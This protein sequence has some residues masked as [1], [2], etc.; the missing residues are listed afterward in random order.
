MERWKADTKFP[1]Y[2]VSSLAQVR[3]ARTGKIKKQRIHASG[4]PTVCLWGNGKWAKPNSIAVHRL[5][6]R[7]FVPGDTSLTVN[8]KNG[9]KTDNR[10]SNLEWVTAAENV[11]HARRTGLTVAPQGEKCGRSK[12]VDSE[13]RRIRKLYERG[14]TQ[15]AIA[16]MFK[17]TQAN[18]SEI[19][20]YKT[21]K[22]I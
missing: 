12:L 2:E 4:Y 19:V 18:V 7:A 14:L 6:A 11:S 1:L 3:N 21:W 20:R 8:H 10:I 13:V 5:V 16:P 22:H 9:I 17:L 15:A